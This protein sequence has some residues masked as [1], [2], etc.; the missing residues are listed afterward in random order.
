MRL[1]EEAGDYLDS[2]RAVSLLEKLLHTPDAS[3][4]AKLAR[5]A[6]LFRF[7]HLAGLTEEQLAYALS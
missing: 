4:L 5:R 1:L 7:G 3:M 6:C 2:A